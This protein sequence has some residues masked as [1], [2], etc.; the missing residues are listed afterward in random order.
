MCLPCKSGIRIGN[1]EHQF[2]RPIAQFQNFWLLPESAEHFAVD[3]VLR[4]GLAKLIFRE[5]RSPQFDKALR[6]RKFPAVGI[7]ENQ[8][9]LLNIRPELVLLFTSEIERPTS[10]DIEN[11]GLLKCF[12][13][14]CEAYNLPI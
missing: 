13:R 10:A 4:I 2:P 6:K 3:E 7:P 8:P 12:C 5:Q 14:I 9:A 1:K 11:R